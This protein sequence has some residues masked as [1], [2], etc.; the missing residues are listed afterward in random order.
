MEQVLALNRVS[1]LEKKV[2]VFLPF[3]L[4]YII[5]EAGYLII[6]AEAAVPQFDHYTKVA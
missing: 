5:F 1:Y 2:T 4:E 6:N 3:V